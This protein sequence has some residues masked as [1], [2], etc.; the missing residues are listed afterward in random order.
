[1]KKGLPKS[2]I[3]NRFGKIPRETRNTW[4]A[5]RENMIGII[6]EFWLEWD[7][8]TEVG[9]APRAAE[10][11][12]LAAHNART[13]KSRKIQQRLGKAVNR[14][15]SA[16]H[17]ASLD[18]FPETASPSEPDNPVGGQ[19]T[20]WPQPVTGV[21]LNQHRGGSCRLPSGAANGRVYNHIRIGVRA[22]GL[23]DVAQ[24]AGTSPLAQRGRKQLFVETLNNASHP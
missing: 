3:F 20:P 10:V 2:I 9:A 12:I 5:S 11:D 14:V 16:A 23:K 7:L 17:A 18:Q 8:A 13:T 19:Y 21:C 4:E 24:A 15:R 1:M 22:H 6:L